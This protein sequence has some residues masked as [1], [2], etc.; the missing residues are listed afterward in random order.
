VELV[1]GVV[2]D[3]LPLPV[4]VVESLVSDGCNKDCDAEENKSNEKNEYGIFLFHTISR[5]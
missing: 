5:R 1:D 3:V 4:V 2:V